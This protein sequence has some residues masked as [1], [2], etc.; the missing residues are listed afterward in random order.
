MAASDTG[1]RRRKPRIPR[2]LPVRFGSEAR[3]CGGVAIDI[4]EGGLRVETPENFPVNSIVQVFVQFPRHSVRLRARVAWLGGGGET[5]SPALGLAFTHPEPTLAKAYKE[6]LAEIKLAEQ[7]VLGAPPST[8]G[9]APPSG[10]AVPQPPDAAAATPGGAA[11]APAA[12][13]KGPIRRRLE[14]RRGNAYDVLIER[15][16]DGWRLVIVQVP[17][18]LG[19]DAPDHEVEYPDFAGAERALKEFVRD[20]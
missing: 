12:E 4:S 9:A 16:D 10:A 8:G 14:T 2:R 7:D 6:W 1:E 3:M 15:R 11:A 13:P 5:G 17:R 19:V 20:H 18:Q